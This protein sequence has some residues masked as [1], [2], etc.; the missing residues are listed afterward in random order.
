M[1]VQ[2]KGQWEERERRGGERKRGGTYNLASFPKLNHIDN[3][4]SGH[5]GECQSCDY[6]RPSGVYQYVHNVRKELW[7]D[8]G[9]FRREEGVG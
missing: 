3:L 9:Q 2:G 7:V 8:L 6:L 5:Y 4:L 1:Q